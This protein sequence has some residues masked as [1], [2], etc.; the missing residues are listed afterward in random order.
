MAYDANKYNQNLFKTYLW[1]S[2]EFTFSRLS[3]LTK[4]NKAFFIGTIDEVN[5]KISKLD[6]KL[7]K[8]TALVVESRTS[9][10]EDT[11]ET[12]SVASAKGRDRYEKRGVKLFS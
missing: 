5:K 2:L 10:Y 12:M 3:T 4:K 1:T 9:D 7:Q 8:Y 6:R 11:D